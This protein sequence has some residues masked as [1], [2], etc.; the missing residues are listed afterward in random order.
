MLDGGEGSDG[1]GEGGGV[2]GTVVEG[3]TDKQIWRLDLFEGEQYRRVMVKVRCCLLRV[4]RGVDGDGGEGRG[5]GEDDDD[6]D[7]DEVEAET[8]VWEDQGGKGLE[9]GEWDFEEFRREKMRR[10][11]GGKEEYA[12]EF[13]F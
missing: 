8:Y 11:V 2:R 3:L 4:V 6:D 13:L 5:D 10:W 12:G 7:D 1:E 9:E